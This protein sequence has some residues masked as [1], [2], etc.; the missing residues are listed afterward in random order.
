[1]TAATLPSRWSLDLSP[2]KI[3]QERLEAIQWIAFAAMVIDHVDV[4]FLGDLSSLRFIGR[5]AFPLFALV[6]AW[7][8][9]E[10]LREHPNRGLLPTGHRLAVAGLWAQGI[11]WLMTNGLNEANVMF[12]FLTALCVISLCA[13]ERD[14]LGIDWP[15]RLT[16]A[17]AL[18]A[19][20]HRNIDYGAPGL[21]LLLGLFAYFRWSSHEG[22]LVAMASLIAMSFGHRVHAAFLAAPVALFLVQAKAPWLRAGKPYA[23]AFYVLYPVHLGLILI[24]LTITALRAM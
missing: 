1:M 13:Q 18:M 23:S 6:F 16:L 10:T 24:T 2:P 3:N 21:C 11:F 22:L 5:F 9:A 15:R 19:L 17:F 7:R 4:F 8:L 14:F 12:V 20:T